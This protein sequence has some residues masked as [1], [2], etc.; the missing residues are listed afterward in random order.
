MYM[1]RRHVLASMARV[2]GTLAFLP[3]MQQLR[4]QDKGVLPKRFVFV[5]KG[6][7][8]YPDDITPKSVTFTP[9]KKQVHKLNKL[10]LSRCL[11]ALEAHHDQTTVIRGLSNRPCGGSHSGFYG[12]LGCYFTGGHVNTTSTPPEA[13]TI[14]CLLG[15]HLPSIYNNLG[16]FPADGSTLIIPAFIS[17][18]KARLPLPFYNSPELTY[19]SLFGSVLAGVGKKEFDLKNDLIDNMISDVGKFSRELT[20]YQKEKMDH[21]V[22]N[23]ESLKTRNFKVADREEVLKKHVD[24]MDER[25]TQANINVV[26]NTRLHFEMASTALITGMTNVVT[27]RPNNIGTNYGALGLT[28]AN[29]HGIG[30][31]NAAGQESVLAART[32]IRRFHCE[33]ISKL[34]DK[35]K[36][37]P[38]GDG[39]M[40]DNT[41]FVYTSDN[42]ETHHSGGINYPIMIL[43]DMGGRLARR[44]YFAP[45]NDEKLERSQPGYTRLGD[46]WATLL[47]AA[48]QP[49]E[50]FGIPVNGVAH[51]PIESLLA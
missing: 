6:S 24:A 13:I 34:A 23:F 38:E 8:F 42:G 1:N 4:A 3:L 26:Q 47:A 49:F 28:G 44:R 19:K 17:A 43:G 31:G 39:T 50:N 29:V 7:G 46:V 9:E 16:F 45:G 14:D 36:V 37:I 35:L 21:Y 2:T 51:A 10:E 11:Q 32:M 20:G 12:G 22:E 40:L 30:H 25:Y 33:E 15:K 18:I 48:D 41:V 27:I 5:V